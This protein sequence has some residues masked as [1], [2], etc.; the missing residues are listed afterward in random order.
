VD[1]C[2]VTDSRDPHRE[3]SEPR[4]SLED[5]SERKRKRARV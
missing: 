1:A 2:Y 4:R 5:S 3:L